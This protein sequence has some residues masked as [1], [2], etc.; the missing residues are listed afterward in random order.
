MLREGGALPERGD[1][2]VREGIYK[3][4][5]VVPFTIAFW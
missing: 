2:A 3:D 1:E 5:D 4:D